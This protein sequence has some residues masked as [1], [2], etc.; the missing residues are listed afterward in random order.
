[1]KLGKMWTDVLHGEE[2]GQD[3]RLRKSTFSSLTSTGSCT[4]A[5]VDKRS[6]SKNGYLSYW[7]KGSTGPR[8]AGGRQKH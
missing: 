6:V 2:A 5:Y 4:E 3:D 1:M 7:G 8:L